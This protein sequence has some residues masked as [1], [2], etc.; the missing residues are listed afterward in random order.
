MKRLMTRLSLALVIVATT[1]VICLAADPDV[2][3]S[4]WDWL[5]RIFIWAAGG[6]FT[7]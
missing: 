3:Q 6:W 4:I 5:V 7:Y 1:P 2:E